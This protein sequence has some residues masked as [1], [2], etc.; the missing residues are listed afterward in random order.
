M[1]LD[2]VNLWHFKFC[3]LENHKCGKDAFSVKFEI[4]PKKKLFGTNVLFACV[5]CALT[6]FPIN[7]IRSK[8]VK[9]VFHNIH[10]VRRHIMEGDSTITTA[11]HTFCYRVVNILL[12]PKIIG[13]MSRN[14]MVLRNKR[15]E[16]SAAQGIPK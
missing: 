3:L 1:K 14:E 6:Y 13:H 7:T 5:H 10:L 8:M 15:K 2:G 12:V 9:K 16:S 11:P 4:N